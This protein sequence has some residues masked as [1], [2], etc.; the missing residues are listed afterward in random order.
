VLVLANDDY[1]LVGPKQFKDRQTSRKFEAELW[2]L[3]KDLQRPPKPLGRRCFEGLAVST[4]AP[5]ISYA[6]SGNHD[7]AVGEPRHL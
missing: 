7:P 2:V 6:V 3:D 5:R 4:L 1:L